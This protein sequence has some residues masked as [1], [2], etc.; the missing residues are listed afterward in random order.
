[1]P[2]EFKDDTLG[3]PDDRI[4]KCPPGPE[5]ANIRSATPLGFAKAV[6][7]ANAPHLKRPANDN[8]PAKNIAV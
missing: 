2:E 8:E 6:F 5:R 1:M 7:L 3:Q 4:H